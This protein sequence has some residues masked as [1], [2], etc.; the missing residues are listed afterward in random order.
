MAQDIFDKIRKNRGPIG[1]YSKGVH[2]YFTF[3]KLE[4]ELGNKMIFRGKECLVWSIN[5]YLGLANHPEVRK[6][7]KEAAEQY[8]MAYPMGARMMTGQ[9][10]EHEKLENEIAEFMGKE[11]SILL[12]SNK[13]I[14]F[15]T[16]GNFHFDTGNN[17]ENKFIVN[18]PNIYLGLQ[19]NGNYPIDSALLGDK[20][21][22]WLIELLDMIEGLMNDIK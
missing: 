5:N 22:E 6:A 16:N 17:G 14:G 9:T 21:E 13:V 19:N 2:G 10:S 1:Q 8:G 20:T 3:P 15:S 7:D 4:G 18:A 12:F 11:D